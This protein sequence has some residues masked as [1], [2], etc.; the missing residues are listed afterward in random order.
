MCLAVSKLQPTGKGSPGGAVVRQGC[1]VRRRGR[2]MRGREAGVQARLWSSNLGGY[3][4][5]REVVCVLGYQA[6]VRW[7]GDMS[8]ASLRGVPCGGTGASWLGTG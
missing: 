3:L 2:I 7:P 6:W 4:A 1:K 8:V 5:E